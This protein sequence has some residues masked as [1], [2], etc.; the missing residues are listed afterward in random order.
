MGDPMTSATLDRSTLR[1]PSHLDSP[2]P[3][4]RITRPAGPSRQAPKPRHP[5][6]DVTY[7]DV[8]RR[9]RHDAEC[10]WLVAMLTIHMQAKLVRRARIAVFFRRR[11]WS[12]DIERR[13]REGR[14]LNIF[15]MLIV[16]KYFDRTM[17]DDCA[18]PAQGTAHAGLN[19]LLLR[20]RDIK[21]SFLHSKRNHNEPTR[22]DRL[23]KLLR[24]P[25]DCWRGATAARTSR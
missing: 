2:P 13:L 21:M 17:L 3:T 18:H 6:A 11:R 23:Y 1:T 15:E 22:R 24:I 14:M 16:H 5:D 4:A 10:G 12:G 9:V 20:Q 19:H 25:A 7:M 8:L